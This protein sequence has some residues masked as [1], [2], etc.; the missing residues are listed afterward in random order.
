M[1]YFNMFQ[2]GVQALWFYQ[3][4]GAAPKTSACKSWSKHPFNF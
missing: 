3:C 4:H 1:A 2:Y